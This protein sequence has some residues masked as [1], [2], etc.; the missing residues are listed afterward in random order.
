MDCGLDGCYK[1]N[2]G[3]F[4]EKMKLQLSLDMVDLNEALCYIAETKDSIDIVE[5]GTPFALKCG[6]KAISMIKEKYPNKELLADYKIMDGGNYEASMAFD[7]GADIVTVLGVSNDATI[8]G[9]IS[10]A[11]KFQR[12]I[13]VD[14][15]GV[16]EIEKR[17][18][19]I[20][21]L[22]VD[23]LCVHTGVDVQNGFNSPI[24][25]FI[26]AKKIL[27]T[28]K[29]AIAGGLNVR[30]IGEIVPYQPDIV[31]VGAGITS[32]PDR[33]KAAADIKRKLNEANYEE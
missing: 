28:T 27:T 4:G 13:M 31:V 11:R 6:V 7:A 8:A 12:K 24:A 9:A 22:G 1:K 18:P 14:L 17:I 21:K 25:Q 16:V 33:A 20:E 30:N 3:F 29:L 23:Y 32:E 26:L 10:A 2:R 19:L 15:I 5:V